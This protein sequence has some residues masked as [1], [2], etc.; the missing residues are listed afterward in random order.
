MTKNARKILLWSP[1]ILGILV[2]LFIGLFALDAF[3]DGFFATL[4]HLAPTILLLLVVAVSW[5]YEWVGGGVFI[6]LSVLYGIDV[7]PRMD[8]IFAISGPLFVVGFLFL[9]SWRH[10]KELHANH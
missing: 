3:D 7:F 8:W 10:R 9:W 5:R 6:A 1:R 4:I 2:A